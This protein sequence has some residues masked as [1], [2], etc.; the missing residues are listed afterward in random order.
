M[1]EQST[2]HGPFLD[3]CV[4]LARE[5]LDA[6]DD[7]FGS[8]LVSG[9]GVVLAEARNKEQTAAD[10]TAHPELELAIWANRN[11]STNERAA[12]TVYTSGEHCP[13]C[14]A[15]HGWV[16]LGPIV[17]AASSA[18]L[19]TWRA[20]WGLPDSPVASIPASAVLPGT[21]VVGPVSPYDELMM[22]IHQDAAARRG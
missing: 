6:G 1:T 3:R 15:A 14:A 19:T 13:M 18:Q 5:A 11:L 10:P 9:A 21:T 12:A 16:G 4:E 7:P 8:V 20:S 22:P 2:D 17:F